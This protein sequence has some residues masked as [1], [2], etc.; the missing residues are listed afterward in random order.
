LGPRRTH[1]RRPY[2]SIGQRAFDGPC[3]KVHRDVWDMG[4]PGWSFH[5]GT[6]T[7]HLQMGL[8]GRWGRRRW[9]CPQSNRLGGGRGIHRRRELSCGSERKHTHTGAH[10]V[11]AMP[12]ARTRARTPCARPPVSN[13]AAG[14]TNPTTFAA[15]TRRSCLPPGPR[16]SPR[17]NHL[18]IVPLFMLRA[19]NVSGTFAMIS[20]PSYK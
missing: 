16:Q 18:A 13:F 9:D 12:A 8:N 11:L 4:P 20:R 3:S 10:T 5:S 2:R 7:L 15:K 17:Q 6:H 19:P 1:Q 14:P